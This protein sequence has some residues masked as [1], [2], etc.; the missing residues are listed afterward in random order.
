MFKYILFG[1]YYPIIHPINL[2]KN[3]HLSN[4]VGGYS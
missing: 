3:T 1:N 2:V 4:A